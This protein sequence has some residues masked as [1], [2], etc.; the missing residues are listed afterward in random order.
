[1]MIYETSQN[2]SFLYLL[3]DIKYCLG[4][5]AHNSDKRLKIKLDNFHNPL[6]EQ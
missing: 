5:N 1:M 3:T 4:K 2:S 6:F